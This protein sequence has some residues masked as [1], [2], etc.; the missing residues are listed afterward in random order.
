MSFDRVAKELR[1][2]GIPCVEGLSLKEYSTFRIGGR[3]RLALFPRSVEELRAAV[4]ILREAEMPLEIIGNGSNI[5]FGD[6][7][8]RQTLIFTK[9]MTGLSKEGNRLVAMAGVSLA[10]LAAKAAEASLSGLEFVRGIPGTVGGAIF[11]NAGAYGGSVSD[12]LSR[13][14]AMDIETG[15]LLTLSEHEF[16]Y[17]H[18]LYMKQRNL[19]CLG[20]TFLLREGNQACILEKM[21]ELAHCRRE[22]QPL[23]YPSAGSYFKRPDGYFSGKLI[24]DCGLKG[25]R[26]GDAAVSEK[27]AGFLINLGKAT[28]EDVLRLEE[29]VKIAVMKEFGVA[30][31]REVRLIR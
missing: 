29:I 13:S 25:M 15:K 10:S 11:M 26:V 14:V 18:S 1:E 27:H 20:G 2:A 4:R 22:K 19:I 7:E 23:D 8:L 28:A 17:R 16:G 5:L 12:V 9:E 3:A 6:G 31:E 24:E 30:L 21:R